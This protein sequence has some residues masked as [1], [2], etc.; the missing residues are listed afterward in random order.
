MKSN[1]EK[2]L[3]QL[4]APYKKLQQKQNSH[5]ETKK[6]GGKVSVFWDPELGYVPKYKDASI[7]KSEKKEEQDLGLSL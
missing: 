7:K 3:E 5:K 4:N 2:N 6:D 1:F